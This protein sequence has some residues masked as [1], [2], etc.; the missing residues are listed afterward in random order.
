MSRWSSIRKENSCMNAGFRYDN[1]GLPSYK[2]QNFWTYNCR[3]LV[4]NKDFG[5][6]FISQNNKQFV[7][8]VVVIEFGTRFFPF[9]TYKQKHLDVNIK[10]NL[11]SS[12]IVVLAEFLRFNIHTG[13][14]F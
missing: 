7:E 6:H 8:L 10:C 9:Y 3:G 5:K 14:S 13:D 4:Q 12:D 11:Q 2:L 1:I